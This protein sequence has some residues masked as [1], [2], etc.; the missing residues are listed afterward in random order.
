VPFAEYRPFGSPRPGDYTPGTK[1]GVIATPTPV[2]ILVCFEA[3]Y[4]ALAR[5]LVRDGATVL[6][7]PSHDGWF[8][9]PSTRE[10]H[11]AAAVF[12]AVEL[13]RPLVRVTNAG[14]TAA[15]DAAGRVTRFPI[16]VAGAFAVDVTPSNVG[17]AYARFGDAFAGLAVAIGVGALLWSARLG[18]IPQV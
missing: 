2:G 11:F 8:A 6:V 7:N 3:I 4:P 13:R 12:R 5:A 16:D 14:V 18:D 9:R 15:V 1:R 17:T 10:Q